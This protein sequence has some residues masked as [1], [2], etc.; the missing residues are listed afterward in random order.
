MHGSIWRARFHLAHHLAN[1]DLTRRTGKA[2]ATALAAQ[3]LDEAGPDQRVDHF[4]QMV[5]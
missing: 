3:A 4:H 2:Q 1:D 5:S